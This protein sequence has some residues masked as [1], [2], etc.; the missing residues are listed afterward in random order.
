[1]SY[2][3]DNQYLIRRKILKL[4]GGSFH[5]YNK[6]QKVVGFSKM[7]A[8]KLKEDLRIYTGEDM[9]EEIL[10]IKARSVIDFSAT[11]DVHDSKTNQKIGA[12]KREG[13]K[14]MLKDEWIILN[15][16]DQERGRIKEDSMFLAIL[17][18]FIMN[19][20][21]Q[22]FSC[23]INGKDACDFKQNL[24]PFVGKI[25]VL[26]KNVE[27]ADRNLIMAGGILLC[28]IEGKQS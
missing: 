21:P 26:F 16:Q 17:R 7:A 14:S 4:F 25:E 3:S 19:L 6:N 22:N 28:A 2:F 1:M 15:A 9:T 5:I 10:S 24:N 18:R 12:L 20:I 8:F 23:T 13:L 11:Y 27:D